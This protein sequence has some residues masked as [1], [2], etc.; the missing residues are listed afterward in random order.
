MRIFL[1]AAT[2]AVGLCFALGAWGGGD[3]A[4]AAATAMTAFASA[5][6]MTRR[7]PA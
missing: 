2:V 3:Y 5:A 6:A 7:A 1:P 4:I